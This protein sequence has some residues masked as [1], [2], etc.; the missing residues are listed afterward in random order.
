MSSMNF[1]KQIR[2]MY[3]SA[4]TNR[5]SKFLFHYALQTN[6]LCEPEKAIVYCLHSLMLLDAFAISLCNRGLKRVHT[7]S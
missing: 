6:Q 1:L 7:L 5:I 3:K 4:H 2:R